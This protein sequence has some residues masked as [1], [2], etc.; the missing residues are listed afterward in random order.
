MALLKKSEILTSQDIPS[1]IIEV[2]EWG[3]QVYVT[4]LSGTER[5]YFEKMVTQ[6]RRPGVV[7]Y[8]TSNIR[9]KLCSLGI[10]DQDTGKRMFDDDEIDALG[11]KSRSALDRVAAAIQRLSAISQEDVDKLAKN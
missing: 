4:G 6:M 10:K 11:K 7:N 5:D 2:P 9:A 1:E 8:D 3:G